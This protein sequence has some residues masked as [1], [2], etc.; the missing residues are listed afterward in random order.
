MEMLVNNIKVKLLD[1]L[2]TLT[3]HNTNITDKSCNILN[4]YYFENMEYSLNNIELEYNKNI[5][6]M[7]CRIL[8]NI[9]Q[10]IKINMDYIKYNENELKNN[11]NLYNI[12]LNTNDQILLDDFAFNCIHNYDICMK[13][14]CNVHEDEK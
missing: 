5:T 13:L 3:L 12:A 7:G 14:E 1:N 10:N 2:E 11:L 8:L 9:Q 4:N 6:I